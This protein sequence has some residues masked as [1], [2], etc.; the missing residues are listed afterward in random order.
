MLL[1][2]DADQNPKTGWLGY[3]FILNR[4][5][6]RLQTTTLQRNVAGTYQ[7]NQPNDI[8]CRLIGNQLE[9]AIPRAAL[10]ITKRPATLDFKWADNI[11]Q[12]GDPADFTQNG[13][14]APNARFNYR[15]VIK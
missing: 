12:T 2:I 1:F 5:N 6:I 8:P 3:D 10:G 14:T 4:T 13:D 15:A 9:L 7:W 11:E